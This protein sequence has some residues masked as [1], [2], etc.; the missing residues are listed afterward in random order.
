LDY[1]VVARYAADPGLQKAWRSFARACT[2][3]LA[4]LPPEARAWIASADEY[5]EGRITADQ[6][7]AIRKADR[8]F[9]ERFE[10]ATLEERAALSATKHRLWPKVDS[11]PDEWHYT[12]WYFLHWCASA[13]VEEPILVELLREHIGPFLAAKGTSLHRLIAE[14]EQD[15]TADGGA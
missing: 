4:D 9:D 3:R 6:L 14:A 7:T 11:D 12:A 5:D 15:A 8:F 2:H 13:G 1:L 10:Q